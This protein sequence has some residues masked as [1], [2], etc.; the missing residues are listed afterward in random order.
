MATRSFTLAAVLLLYT[1]LPGTAEKRILDTVKTGEVLIDRDRWG[2]PHIYGQSARAVAFGAGYAQAEDHLDGMLRLFL[3]ARGE[4]SRVE[5][6][7]AFANDLAAR[8][9]MNHEI[10][11]GTWGTVPPASRDYYQAFADGINRYMEAHA[12]D[13]QPWYWTVTAQDVATYLRYVVMRYSLRVAMAKLGGPGATPPGEGS[14]AFAV[15]GTRSASGHAMLHADPHLPWSGENRMGYEMHLQCPQFDIAGAAFFGEPIPLIGH[16]ANVAWTATNNAANTAD[17]FEEKIDPQNPDRYLDSDGQ[18]K[19]MEKHTVRIEVRQANGSLRP[20]E[21]VLRYTRRGPVFESHGKTYSVAIPRWKDFPDPLTG[22]IERAGARNISEF[23]DSLARSPM[24]KWNLIVADSHGDIFYVDNAIFPKRASGYNYNKPVP[25]WEPEAQWQGYVAFAD[26]PQFKNP[27]NGLIV[28]CNNSPYSTAQPALLD[29]ANFSP[30]LAHSLEVTNIPS[31]RAERA[32]DMFQKHA[33]V[34]WED[35]LQ[36]AMDLKVL[37]ADP[38]LRSL[39]A[40]AEGQDDADAR[41]A[42][43]LLRNWDERAS[44]DSRALPI[45]L[46]WERLLREQN[47]RLAGPPNREQAIATLKQTLAEMKQLYGK[48]S[49]PFGDVQV[50]SHGTDYP[51]PGHDSLFATQTAYK[52]GKWHVNGGS[53]WLMLI[54]FSTPLKVFTIAPQGESD[55]PASPHFADQTVMFSKQ[56]M[57]PFPFTD[58]E[59]KSLSEKSYRLKM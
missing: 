22:H 2:I 56:E 35:H 55:N 7:P 1:P 25:G 27:P 29:P 51:I 38:Y 4:L 6:Q 59:V 17:V 14:N 8:K 43:S 12:Q 5:G 46:H 10:A 49:V 36:V 11:A 52:N 19:A 32:F 57:K 30:Y 45:L 58:G 44:L 13:K 18:W 31:S 48:I 3:M 47:R 15:S 28:Q 37:H 40:A 42:Y 33:K 20:V 26:L 21:Q 50:F 24:D 39:I 41:E 9:L 34:S 53:S 16:N 54:E 23:R